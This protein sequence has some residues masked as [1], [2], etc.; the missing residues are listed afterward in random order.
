MQPMQQLQ[1]LL[2][3]LPKEQLSL[4][5]TRQDFFAVL[6]QAFDSTAMLVAQKTDTQEALCSLALNIT[7]KVLMASAPASALQDIKNSV[8][9]LKM[10][11]AIPSIP[12]I[13]QKVDFPIIP[14]LQQTI[15]ITGFPTFEWLNK[16]WTVNVPKI[17]VLNSSILLSNNI[18]QAQLVVKHVNGS[19]PS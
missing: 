5:V 2:D 9:L 4:P 17:P 13:T 19:T 7:S 11:A 12:N 18:T 6:N 15:T 10:P 14:W 16:S 3:N 8:F 1:A